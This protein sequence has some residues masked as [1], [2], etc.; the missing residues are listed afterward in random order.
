MTSE[1]ILAILALL[2][3]EDL[4]DLERDLDLYAPVPGA[5]P[6]PAFVLADEEPIPCPEAPEYTPKGW[7]MAA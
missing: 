6:A 5:A 2:P 1:L 4:A 3:L 7:S